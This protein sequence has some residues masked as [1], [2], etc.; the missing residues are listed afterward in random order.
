[1]KTHR[2]LGM[3]WAVYCGYSGL[4]LLRALLSLHPTATGH[5]DAWGVLAVSL[6][7]D[8]T[9]IV[10][11]IFLFRGAKWPR[12]I[13]GLIAVYTGF[14]SIAFIVATG[15]LPAWSVPTSIFALVSLVLLLLPRHEP[16]A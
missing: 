2:I 6:L 9:G 15:S 3:L 7:L 4:N 8:L 12:W 10:A 13:V 16:V 5:W 11:S 1:M 14:G